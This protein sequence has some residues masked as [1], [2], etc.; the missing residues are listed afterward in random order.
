[1]LTRSRQSWKWAEKD[2]LLLSL[3]NTNVRSNTCEI[4]IFIAL[5][6]CILSQVLIIL[7]F[8]VIQSGMNYSPL[9]KEGNKWDFKAS[10]IKF[11]IESNKHLNYVLYV[12]FVSK[13]GV[14]RT[15]DETLQGCIVFRDGIFY[16]LYCHLN[17]WYC[18]VINLLIHS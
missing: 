16:Y 15:H 5:I 6:S 2:N 14:I 7:K 10:I 13:K 18:N 4:Y 11:P 3:L 8:N 9:V 12:S 1:M 17:L